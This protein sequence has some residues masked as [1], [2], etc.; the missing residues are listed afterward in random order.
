MQEFVMMVITLYDKGMITEIKKDE[1][2]L[3]W[4]DEK[5]KLFLNHHFPDT[6]PKKIEYPHLIIQT[7]K[8]A[9]KIRKSAPSSFSYELSKAYVP[10]QIEEDGEII[11][12][13]LLLIVEKESGFI[14]TA[15]LVSPLQDG[16]RLL[17]DDLEDLMT[18]FGKPKELFVCNEEMLALTEDFCRKFDIR[19]TKKK[20]LPEI[21]KAR[22]DFFDRFLR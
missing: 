18:K 2:I 20:S 6:F 1:F 15:E 11:I 3:R 13:Q 4:Y 16:N 19:L 10:T 21:Q 22:T 7:S 17:L 14:V 5:S 12:P 8:A 9:D